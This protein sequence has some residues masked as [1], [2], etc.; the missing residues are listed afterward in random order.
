MGR[1]VRITGSG[2][3]SGPAFSS[4]HCC[5]RNRWMVKAIFS[6]NNMSIAFTVGF[7]RA[8]LEG[9]PELLLILLQGSPLEGSWW[10]WER[11]KGGP[12]PQRHRRSPGWGLEEFRVSSQLCSVSGWVTTQRIKCRH[13]SEMLRFG[14]DRCS[15]ACIAIKWVVTFLVVESL[16][17]SL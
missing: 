14:P 15:K 9:V 1:V 5:R 6:W 2:L 7:M 8:W 10:I 12:L 3:V 4:V 16:A 17:F 13:T 11:G